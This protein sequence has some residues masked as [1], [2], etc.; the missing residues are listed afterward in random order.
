MRF[1]LPSFLA[2][3]YGLRHLRSSIHR[4]WCCGKKKRFNFKWRRLVV[5][6]S[7]TYDLPQGKVGRLFLEMLADTMDGILAGQWNS[8]RLIV[9]QLVML[10]RSGDVKQ[11]KDVKRR[12]TKRLEA[13]SEGKFEMLVQDA[14]WSLQTHL[15]TKQGN[16]SSARTARK[17][18]QH[19]D[20]AWRCQRSSQTPN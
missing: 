3:Q 13:W 15:S 6:P 7:Q 4:A 5:F 14:E 11:S 12:M 20:A 16:V 2:V 18:L 9:F 19:E 8:E 17:N 10:Q 1:C